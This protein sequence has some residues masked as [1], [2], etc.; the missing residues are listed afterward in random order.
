MFLLGAL[1]QWQG[2]SSALSTVSKHWSHFFPSL[3]LSPKQVMTLS[4]GRRVP[5]LLVHVKGVGR[6]LCV[7]LRDLLKPLRKEVPKALGVG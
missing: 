7:L 2:S 6:E 1:R 4:Q 5:S 3:C